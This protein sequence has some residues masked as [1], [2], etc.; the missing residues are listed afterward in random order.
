MKTK[1]NHK[2]T[3]S[4][5]FTLIEIVL[6]TAIIAV[7]AGLSFSGIRYYD[8]KMKYSR[9]EVLIASIE[10]ALEEYKADNGSYPQSNG[11]SNQLFNA[12]YGDG[13][14]YLATLSPDIEGRQRNVDVAPNGNY[15]VV[16][17]WGN[18]IRYRHNPSPKSDGTPREMANP[19]QDYDLISR[20]PNGVGDID[21]TSDAEKAD[22]IKNW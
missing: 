22:D 2:N 11:G 15:F 16:D 3:L 9:T 20:G 13:I 12:L 8:E 1:R 18:A 4:Y 17:A 6:A 10:S 14:V 21:S 19:T 5:G 7:L